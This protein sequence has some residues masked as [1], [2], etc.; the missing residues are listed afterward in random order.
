MVLGRGLVDADGVEHPMA[1][2]LDHV[3]SFAERRR[4]LGY[5]SVRHAGPLPWPEKLRGHEFHYSVQ[6]SPA[7]GAPLYQ[8]SDAAGT[9]LPAA[10]AVRGTVC[11]SYL[12][13]L[14]GA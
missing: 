9:G 2:L 12:H 8:V 14:D 3:T 7:A 1:G 5:R 11:G 10:G 6:T 13:I 4:T